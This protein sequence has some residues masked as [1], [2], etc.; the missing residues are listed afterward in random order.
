[1]PDTH[2]TM[3]SVFSS[4][5]GFYSARERLRS[6]IDFL[7]L[8]HVAIGDARR[9]RRCPVRGRA[10]LPAASTNVDRNKGHGVVAKDVDDF[11]GYCEAAPLIV[12]VDCGSEFEFPIVAGAEALPFVFENEASGPAVFEFSRGQFGLVGLDAGEGTHVPEAQDESLAWI[13]W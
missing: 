10:F 2:P 4:G 8:E 11:D 7:R 6:S 9:S 13:R 5:R 12:S 1:V 3:T